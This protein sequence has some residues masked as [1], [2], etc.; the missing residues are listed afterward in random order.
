MSN[1]PPLFPVE[2]DDTAAGPNGGEMLRQFFKHWATVLVCLL[3]VTALVWA[4]VLVQPSQYESTA[5]V[6]V[7]TEQQGTPA[8]LS[9]IASFRESQVP[10]SVN[11]I[12][13]T[14]MQ[15]L[16]SRS[17]AEVVVDRLGIQPAQLNQPPL[18]SLKAALPQWLKPHHKPV[19]AAARRAATVAL[20]LKGISVEALRSKTA[21]T[22][23]NVME[24]RFV[25]ADKV[26]APLALKILLEQYLHFGSQRSHDMGNAALNLV[27]SK[28]AEQA[29]ELKSLDDQI[30]AASLQRGS[31][32]GTPTAAGEYATPRIARAAD[33]AATLD[34]VL[35]NPRSTSPSSLSLLKAQA[36]DLQAR[37]EEAEQVYTANS[38]NVTRLRNQLQLLRA[39]LNSG[40]QMNG[41]LDTELT[42][43]ERQRA[44]A[45][46]RFDEL[47]MKHD[48]IELYLQM[49]QAE[50]DSRSVTETPS[51]PDK[52]LLK[53]KITLA[54]LGPIAGLFLGLLIAGLREYFDHRLQS[55]DE[56]RRH[57][58]LDTLGVVPRAAR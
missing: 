19:N 12:I 4:A 56:V 15:L 14:E 58:G 18:E 31:R 22:T 11:R 50:A 27:A 57:L 45:V 1:T 39:R 34:P 8:F 9:G 26:L 36:I 41:E 17:N 2:K 32:D 46:A 38:P 53:S 16:L 51:V 49:G 24:V 40:V 13:E 52:P 47:R 3:L 54:L 6:W 55:S 20:F 25:C 29:A 23:S 28:V 44:L 7:Q 30:L 21:E 35:P 43:L 33:G 37:L 42:S 5:K 48:Q 10:E